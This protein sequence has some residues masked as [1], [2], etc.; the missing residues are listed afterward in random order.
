M[1]EH[2]AV[3]VCSSPVHCKEIGRCFSAPPCD[4]TEQSLGLYAEQAEA[5]R[6]LLDK[7]APRTTGNLLARVAQALGVPLSPSGGVWVEWEHLCS[8]KGEPVLTTKDLR[9]RF[10]GLAEADKDDA[11]GVPESGSMG[12]GR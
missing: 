8:Q 11:A 9:C 5:I 7:H 2:C 6:D 1:S 12:G 10:C 4:A 3:G